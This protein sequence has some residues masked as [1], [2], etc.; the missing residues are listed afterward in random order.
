MSLLGVQEA[1]KGI[2]VRLIEMCSLT[3]E[4][5]EDPEAPVSRH[6]RARPDTGNC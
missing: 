2:E 6:P 1:W 5:P 3:P 4:D